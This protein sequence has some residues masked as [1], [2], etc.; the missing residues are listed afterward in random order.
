MNNVSA[1]NISEKNSVLISVIAAAVH[2]AIQ[3]PHKILSIRQVNTTNSIQA[4]L[5]SWSL[6]GRRHLLSSH[7]LR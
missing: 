6:E 2:A 4:S 1:S 7:K 5:L 3:S